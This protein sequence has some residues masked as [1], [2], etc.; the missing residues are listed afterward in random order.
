MTPQRKRLAQDASFAPFSV[1]RDLRMTEQGIL[2]ADDKWNCSK[3]V[4]C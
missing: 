2:S 1:D 3:T 4:W